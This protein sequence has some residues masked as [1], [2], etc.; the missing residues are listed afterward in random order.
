MKIDRY[1][2][3]QLRWPLGL[4]LAALIVHGCCRMC[5]G[6]EPSTG[7]C[8][9]GTACECH[10]G[11]DNCG[12]VQHVCHKGRLSQNSFADAQAQQVS[13]SM[14][15]AAVL[16]SRDA[17]RLAQNSFTPVA[18]V[19]IRP[20]MTADGWNYDARTGSYWR[21]AQGP[22]PSFGPQPFGAA[23]AFAPVWGDQGFGAC[24]AGGSWGGSQG[25]AVAGRG[26]LRRR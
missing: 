19:T 8:R 15:A 11:G 9:C 3:R 22:P 4:L 1:A 7:T 18:A 24:A 20:E 14:P 5:F 23:P 16:P 13:A 26:L 10:Q 6:D 2:L 12:C 25:P 21:P 17:R